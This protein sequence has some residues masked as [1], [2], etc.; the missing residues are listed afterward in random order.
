M[1]TKNPTTS[2][3][4]PKAHIIKASIETE[5]ELEEAEEED[6]LNAKIDVEEENDDEEEEEETKGEIQPPQKTQKE[7]VENDSDYETVDEDEEDED[8]EDEEEA[9]EITYK[10]NGNRKGKADNKG[11]KIS[12]PLPK[13][14]KQTFADREEYF[15][16]S[17]SDEELSN[18]MDVFVN[19][20]GKGKRMPLYDES[21]ESDEFD[22]E[23]EKKIDKVLEKSAKKLGIQIGDIDD[24]EEDEDDDDEEPFID[25]SVSDSDEE[26]DEEDEYEIQK[27]M[28]YFSKS[29]KIHQ[30]N[31]GKGGKNAHKQPEFKP[32]QQKNLPPKKAA[33]NPPAKSKAPTEKFN[34]G[35]V[36]AA[37]R[38]RQPKN[39]LFAKVVYIEY[40]PLTTREFSACVDTAYF[41]RGVVLAQPI[42]K[43]LPTFKVINSLEDMAVPEVGKKYYFT[44]K[45]VDWPSDSNLPYAELTRLI[46][47]SGNIDIEC[48]ALLLNYNV[49]NEEF[50]AQTYDYLKQYEEQ[51]DPLTREFII[52]QAEREKRWDLT[53]EIILTCDPVTA[54]D[55]DDALS[56]KK[57]AE[58]I[59]ELGVHIADVSHF[60]KEGTPLDQDARLRTTSVYLPH[61]V[62]PMLPRLLCENLCS[63]NPG[64]ERLAFSIYLYITEDGVVLDKDKYA[65]RIG[66]SIIKTVGKLNYDQVQDV[67]TGKITTANELPIVYVP[68]GVDKEQV[69]KDILLM[70]RIAQKI[71]T[72][73]FETGSIY[74]EK[75]KNYFKLDSENYPQSYKKE[76]VI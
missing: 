28:E 9:I 33:K 46:G 37:K 58:G 65:P 61:M 36:D 55:L 32:K 47:L 63:L 60:V 76:Q 45:F 5:D 19:M 50:T 35:R 41:N 29:Q 57:F 25:D 59:Y 3:S 70:N 30:N 73:R 2:T 8:E 22:E 75:D 48:D 1:V 66:K 13:K 38:E 24:D 71:R 31:K 56:I 7:V 15:H 44:A 11:K 49:L 52:P 53:N 14:S 26:L 34:K 40:D 4:E 54:R 17:E 43:R 62:I 64:V 10:K 74:F 20:M 39:F 6:M 68:K 21:D 72:R 12:G 16:D 27:A 42:D 23:E 51:L 18:N 67:I 69:I